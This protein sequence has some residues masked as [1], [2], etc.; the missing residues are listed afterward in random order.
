MI[1]YRLFLHPQI[2]WRSIE[3]FEWC[4]LLFKQLTRLMLKVWRGSWT[5]LNLNKMFLTNINQHLNRRSEVKKQLYWYSIAI[6]HKTPRGL[7]THWSKC[8]CAFYRYNAITF[9]LFSSSGS[10]SVSFESKNSEE[11]L[12]EKPQL[13]VFFSSQISPTASAMKEN[14]SCNLKPLSNSP[15]FSFSQEK[16]LTMRAGWLRGSKMIS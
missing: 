10:I 15:L 6:F 11:Q 5:I 16:Q 13:N 3:V 9:K 12:N 8:T 7:I 2:F 14:K 4:T 1:L